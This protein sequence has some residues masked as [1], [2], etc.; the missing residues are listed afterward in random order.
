MKP[1]LIIGPTFI[2]LSFNGAPHVI[3]DNDPRF[4]SIKETIKAKKWDELDTMLNTAKAIAKY[5]FGKVTVYEGEIHVHGKVAHN[6]VTNKILHFMKEDYPFE[7]LVAFLNKLMENPDERSR[8]QLYDFLERYKMPIND[9]GNFLAM[10]AVKK[11]NDDL[12]DKRTGKIRN[13]VGDE[14]FMDRAQ[15]DSDPNNACS[16]S[17]HAGNIDYIKWFGRANDEV[18]LVEINP[19]D[20]VSCPNDHSY[21]KLRVCKYK[22]IKR[23]GSVADVCGFDKEYAPENNHAKDIYSGVDFKGG[24]DEGDVEEDDDYNNDS[25][26][27]TE[28][29]I[30]TFYIAKGDS[31]KKAANNGIKWNIVSPSKKVCRRNM[32]TR[33]AAIKSMVKGFKN[34]TWKQLYRKGY[35]AVQ[36]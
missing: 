30:P 2:S 33:D 21:Q 12:Y 9:E 13:N 5:S 35:R 34:K 26:I 3:F 4:A 6:S 1:S 10:K 27:D 7:P 24:W 32:V 31:V 19:A 14:P 17:L 8:T 25:N 11:I 36:A 29:S 20:V 23:L 28:P 15:C 18:I 16:P 22:V